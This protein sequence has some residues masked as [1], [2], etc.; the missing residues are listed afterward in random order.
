MFM[1]L[2]RVTDVVDIILKTESRINKVLG[3]SS[4]LYTYRFHLAHPFNSCNILIGSK[5]T[6]TMEISINNKNTSL[7]AIN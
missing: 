4:G 6:P 1:A 3:K 5:H 7:H 2:I